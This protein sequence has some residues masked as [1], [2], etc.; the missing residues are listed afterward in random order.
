MVPLTP[1]E[2]GGL[3]SDLRCSYLKLPLGILGQFKRVIVDTGSPADR[4]RGRQ[5]DPPLVTTAGEHDSVSA[6]LKLPGRQ[7]EAQA[8][9]RKPDIPGRFRVAY[10]VGQ[11]GSKV[12]PSFLAVDFNQILGNTGVPEYPK[13]AVHN[14]VIDPTRFGIEIKEDCEGMGAVV[15]RI[16][17]D[18]RLKRAPVPLR[19]TLSNGELRVAALREVPILIEL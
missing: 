3:G 14:E 18:P 1:I 17:S 10:F 6:F 9:D 19:S 8:L 16:L 7:G 5:N 11:F 15:T 12:K 4:L 2:D 13:Q